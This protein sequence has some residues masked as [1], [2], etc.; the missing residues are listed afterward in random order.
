[1]IEGPSVQVAGEQVAIG[2]YGGLDQQILGNLELGS[3]EVTTSNDPSSAQGQHITNYGAND[4]KVAEPRRR[5]QRKRPASTG[6]KLPTQE[7]RTRGPDWEEK[8]KSHFLAVK[9]KVFIMSAMRHRL[10][11]SEAQTR[12]WASKYISK[13]LGKS[14]DS[15]D[16][17]WDNLQKSYKAILDHESKVEKGNFS[18]DSYWK[19]DDHLRRK[20]NEERRRDK[21]HEL[22][23]VFQQAWFENMESMRYIK[24][25]QKGCSGSRN[26]TKSNI[27]EPSTMMDP[28]KDLRTPTSPLASTEFNTDLDSLEEGPSSQGP[29]CAINSRLPSSSH[30]NQKSAIP[31]TALTSDILASTPQTIFQATQRVDDESLP[32][33]C[34]EQIAPLL[35]IIL[36]KKLAPLISDIQAW[37]EDEQKK[38]DEDIE[39]EK[40]KFARK[41]NKYHSKALQVPLQHPVQL[42]RNEVFSLGNAS[43]YSRTEAGPMAYNGETSSANIPHENYHQGNQALSNANGAAFFI[44]GYGGQA[45]KSDA[46]PNFQTSSAY[47]ERY[48]NSSCDSLIST[49]DPGSQS[50]AANHLRRSYDIP[51]GTVANSNVQTSTASFGNHGQRYATYF[52]DSSIGPANIH[53]PYA[54][55][56]APTI[57]HTMDG[58]QFVSSHG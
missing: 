13:K 33:C 45:V 34:E 2:V 57:H 38:R 52:R 29:Q 32:L 12:G 50:N 35:E 1:M 28:A 44:Y 36:Q 46:H 24:D 47:H 41:Q 58:Q 4:E 43:T 22:P 55:F 6:G 26:E 25:F 56:R 39:K 40:L 3:Q 8:E 5:Q 54:S 18:H 14:I 49:I 42:T 37:R 30:H 51:A 9:L 21:L 31:L 10:G 16:G 27:V 20:A 11:K 19:M 7:K 23:P 53:Q 17:Q 15:C 48:W